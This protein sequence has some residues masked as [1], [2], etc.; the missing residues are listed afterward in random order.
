LTPA[1]R[2]VVDE[3]LS[4]GEPR[5]TFDPGIAASLR[6]RFEEALAPLADA[7][8]DVLR[9]SKGALTQVHACEANYVAEQGWPGWNVA[10]CEGEIT[11]R[12]VQLSVSLGGDTTPLELVDHVLE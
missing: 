4:L 6:S 12:A 3:L 9:V 8:P 2:R 7:L 5:P 11:H 1:Q 10:N